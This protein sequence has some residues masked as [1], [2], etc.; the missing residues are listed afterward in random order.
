LG[1]GL[2]RFDPRL[3]HGCEALN[4]R[5]GLPRTPQRRAL[6]EAPLGRR[7]RR[8]LRQLE[9]TCAHMTRVKPSQVKPRSRSPPPARAHLRAHDWSQAKSSQAEIA[10]SSASSSAPARTVK[11]NQAKSSRAH[12]ARLVRLRSRRPSQVK[13]SQV[14]SSAPSSP[15]AAAISAA[16]SSQIKPSQV[17]RT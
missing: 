11:S 1:P 8:L 4:G 15:C 2:V 14:K 7:D 3:E 9:R 12:L 16:E 10:V 5:G 13:S 6:V 17:E